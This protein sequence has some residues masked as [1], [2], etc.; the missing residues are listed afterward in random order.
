MH[1]RKCSYLWGCRGAWWSNQTHNLQLRH[2]TDTIFCRDTSLSYRCNTSH[3]IWMKNTWIK[4]SGGWGHKTSI[5]LYIYHPINLH[6][7][8]FRFVYI[9]IIS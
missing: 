4:Q 8:D 7:V 6:G 5:K 9:F 3:I 1:N 2:E